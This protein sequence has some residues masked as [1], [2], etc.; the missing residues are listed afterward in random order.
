MT[1][2]M[3]NEV[4]GP[5]T[6]T[7]LLLVLMPITTIVMDEIRTGESIMREP[8]QEGDTRNPTLWVEEVR[9]VYLVYER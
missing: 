2:S 7:R 1:N 9:R 4:L 8:R 5:T 6:L 3:R